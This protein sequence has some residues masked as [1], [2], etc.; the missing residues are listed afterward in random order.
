MHSEPAV[1]DM[2]GAGYRASLP[3]PARVRAIVAAA[4]LSHGGAERHA[5]TIVR[6][7]AERGHECHAVHVKDGT[8]Q[9]DRVALP[10][11]VTV[12]CLKANR[13]FDLGAVR[14]FARHISHLSP[15]VIVAANPYALMY[16][17]LALRLSRRR[18]PLAVIFHSN[19]LLTTRERLQMLIYHPLFWTADCSVFVCERQRR[20]WW[21]RGVL[22][23]R[24]EVI[25]NGVDVEEF[26]DQWGSE[27]RAKL[28]AALGFSEPDYVI[29][30]SALLRAEKNHVQL[31][32]AVAI[33][34]KSGIPARALM[35]GDGE[36][37]PRI[38]ARARELGVGGH[39][40][41][42]GLQRDVR[43]YV[44]AC[45]AIALC[46]ST[47]AFSLAAVEAMALG[48]PVVHSD[49]GGAAEMI[50][51]GRNGF[52]FPAGDTGA[53]VERLS[54]LADRGLSERMGRRARAA[55]EAHF[56][57]RSMVDRYED[58]LL[59]LSGL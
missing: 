39:V 44:S 17:R 38:E 16:C 59:E 35:I 28:R 9:L 4:T 23:R 58:L 29:G 50:V 40:V 36:M 57:E 19:R 5:V 42:T 22:S 54:T 26:R 15:T 52:L 55:V 34:R 31:V 10:D 53:L 47:E 11:G 8:A 25:Y 14:D 7:L 51:P 2:L 32:D 41:I 24:N 33:L 48:K 1:R 30:M 37:R 13:Y 56:S 43:P 21:R 3:S 18:V 49:V 45:D 20:Y 46:S 12:R 27:G 6:R